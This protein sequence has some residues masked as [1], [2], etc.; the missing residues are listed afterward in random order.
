MDIPVF[1]KLG[2][3]KGNAQR[4]ISDEDVRAMRTMA[5][6]H[7]TEQVAGAFPHVSNSYVRRVLAGKVR[8]DV[9]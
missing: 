1:T 7:T 6:T 8:R 2:K 9:V 5:W 3:R 4:V